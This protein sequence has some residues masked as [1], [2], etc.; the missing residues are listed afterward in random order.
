MKVRGLMF[1]P[2]GN[3]I[4]VLRGDEGD[5]VLPIW[6]GK[7]EANAISLALESVKLPRPMTHDLIK[8]VLDAIDAKVISVVITDLK[9]NTYFAKIHLTHR[10]AEITIDA[11]PSDAIALALKVESPIF[12]A[13][14]VIQRQ[15]ANEL[16]RWLE[17]LRPEDFG[18]TEA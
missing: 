3:Y 6:V 18:Q 8:N 13:S 2:P 4:V 10:D 11:R 17:N 7:P 16:D 12:V 14:D 5:E 15:G 1:D 9:E